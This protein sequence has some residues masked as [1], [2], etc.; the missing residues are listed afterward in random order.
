MNVFQKE[1]ILGCKMIP[2]NATCMDLGSPVNPHWEA[3]MYV[4]Q[5]KMKVSGVQDDPR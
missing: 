5:R 2:G 4:F 3:K 1:R